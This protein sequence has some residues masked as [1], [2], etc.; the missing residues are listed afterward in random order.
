MA[1]IL[2]RFRTI[3]LKSD[4]LAVAVDKKTGG[5]RAISFS[6][7]PYRLNYVAGRRPFG[8]PFGRFTVR[9]VTCKSFKVKARY[10]YQGLDLT[11]VRLIEGDTIT[12][13]YTFSNPGSGPLAFAAGTL[14]IR[15]PFNDRYEKA[16]TCLKKRCH[17]HIWCGG[18]STYILGEPMNACGSCLGLV[19]L[20][21]E[22]FH[23][24]VER[25]WNSNDRGDFALLLPAVTFQPGEN[26]T[27]R[28]QLKK[29]TDREEFIST[30]KSCPGFAFVQAERYSVSAG[31]QVVCTV[32]CTHPETV[33]F[34][35]KEETGVAVTAEEIAGSSKKIVFSIDPSFSAGSG[36]RDA[37]EKVL[38]IGY[39]SGLTT[40]LVLQVFDNPLAVI[41]RRLHFLIDH[42]QVRDKKSKFYGGFLLYDHETEKTFVEDR[43]F[44]D[45]NAARERSGIITSLLAWL[46]KGV[47]DKA[48]YQKYDEAVRL[49]L[50]FVDREICDDRGVVYENVGYRKLPF[51]RKY[52]YGFYALLYT[53]AYRYTGADYYLQKT[54]KILREYYRLGGSRFYAINIPMASL[55]KLLEQSTHRDSPGLLAEMKSYFIDHCNY[56][57]ARGTSYPR[58]EVNYEQSIVA[59][60][61][62]MLLQGFQISGKEKY[63]AEAER[64]LRLLEAFSFIQPDFRMNEIAIRHWDGY[65]FGK[66]KMYGD[67]FP[68]Y[69]SCLNA[70][71][72]ARYAQIMQDE[73]FTSRADNILLNNLCLI[74]GG[75]GSCAYIYPYWINGKKGGFF[76]PWAND[77]DLLIYFNL[78]FNSALAPSPRCESHTCSENETCKA[79]R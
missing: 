24:A 66:R 67:T 49:A 63:L 71:V 7:D 50:G 56:L 3:N 10:G 38:P 27:V 6:V 41:D 64:Q 20:E 59:P 40:H 26:C 73:T 44:N 65:W 46:I 57:L 62:D 53:L 1:F 43:C 47:E 72:F 5:L 51:Q 55:I 25:R 34:I 8:L 2:K 37:V 68:H 33:K 77:Q 45:R 75:R 21:G 30:L 9:E 36:E 76:D 39:G 14:G 16:A 54:C 11:V 58:H 18:S 69:W 4:A 35:F 78:T 12:E 28:W 13:S 31:E 79:S 23:Y 19:L 61:V 74:R 70:A 60:S 52:N 48:V 32:S 42:Q 22:I 15:T 29:Y 17:G